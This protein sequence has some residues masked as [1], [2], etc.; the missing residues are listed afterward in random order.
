MQQT[1]LRFGARLCVTAALAVVLLG[2][3]ETLRGGSIA[4]TAE[5]LTVVVD[6]GH[7]GFDGGAVGVAGTV[8]AGL[9][10]SVA[11]KLETALAARGVQV[12]MTRTD[13]NALGKTKQED[14]QAR[15]KLLGDA[16]ADAVV[17]VHM[18]IFG[19]AS[20]HGTMAYYM[21]GSGEGQ[22]LAQQV[23]DA[24]TAATGQ[25]QREANPGDYF[26][27]RECSV[28]AVLVECGFLS[29]AAEEAL[30][31]SESYQQTLAD[32]IADGVLAY[33]DA[34]GQ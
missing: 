13:E 18:N 6:A 20:V 27:V 3:I 34:R 32:A 14:M 30:L 23:I 33:F 1:V 25:K 9:N 24:V 17:S 7:G 5:G 31:C 10:L 8:E 19:D 28:P 26:V 29:N 11:K 2:V 4:A 12:L 16:R 21:Q 15:K 22:A